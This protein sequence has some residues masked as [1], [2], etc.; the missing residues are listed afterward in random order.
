M[1]KGWDAGKLK[2]S[3]LQISFFEIKRREYEI[4]VESVN[5]MRAKHEDYKVQPD[6]LCP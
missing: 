4:D 5:E 2:F 1:T 6:S 3:E